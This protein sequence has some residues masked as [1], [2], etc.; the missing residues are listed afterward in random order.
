MIRV[1]DNFQELPAVYLF[2]QI[3]RILAQYKEK[4]EGLPLIRMDIGDISGPIPSSAAHAMK[5]AVEELATKEGFKGY[6][7]EQGYQFLRDLIAVKDYQQRG[8]EIDPTEIFIGDGAKCDLGNLGDILSKEC[9]VAVMDP[10]YPAYIDDNVIDGREG[11]LKDGKY[12]RI[13]YLKSNFENNFSPDLPTDVVDMIYICSPNNPTGA[14]MNYTELKKWVDYARKHKSLIIFDSAY[15]AYVRTPHIPRSIYEIPGAKEVAIE[16]R[17]F[18]KTGGFTGVR[19]GY[20][21]IPKEIVG[22]YQD[23]QPVTLNAL[24]SRRQTTKFNGASYI[25]QKGAAAL[26]SEKGVK[27]VRE[28]TDRILSNAT[29]LRNLF[30]KAGW[31]VTG[32]IDSPY[33][34]AKNPYGWSSR[35]TF[36][37]LLSECGVSTTPG[38]GFGEEGEGYIRLTGFNSKENTD[39]AIKRMEKVV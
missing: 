2:T 32:G 14:V 39:A 1:N 25:S 26:Y 20:T 34:W 18:S 11:K 4:N 33:V 6:G 3:S 5:E 36:D 30:E 17:S 15:E 28:M 24:W 27:E 29:N 22:Y 31:K 38:A 23:G 10:T 8:I 19:C 13:T 35:E 7:P 16:I 37:K 12:N 21:V 9:K